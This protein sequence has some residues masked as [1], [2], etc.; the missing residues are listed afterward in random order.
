MGKSKQ[1]YRK[2]WEKELDGAES[3]GVKSTIG[4]WCTVAKGDDFSG[5]CKVCNSK[6]NVASAGK[7]AIIQHA[8]FSK[9]RDA[10]QNLEKCKQLSITSF[11]KPSTSTEDLARTAEI[12]WAAFLAENDLPMILSDK[13]SDLFKSMFPDSDI[14]KT[15]SCARTKASY[16]ITGGLGYGEHLRIIDRMKASKFS[17]LID[18]STQLQGDK[19][20]HILARMFDSSKEAVVTYFYKAI[21]VNQATAENIASA[22]NASFDADDI[23]WKNVIQIMSDSPNVMRGSK[24]GVLARIKQQYASHLLDIGGCSLHHVHNAV[25]YATSKLG[26]EIEEFA[27]D[28]FAFFKYRSGLWEEYSGLQVLMD[29]PEHHLLRFVSTR[30]LVMLPV[31]N[32]LLEQ[33]SCVLES[34]P[35]NETQFWRCQISVLET[36]CTDMSLPCTW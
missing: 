32:R 10:I 1:R 23:P 20:L 24:S 21:V 34:D 35:A 8:K 9:H 33:W 36:T 6:I 7:H 27:I 14:A 31:V 18:E 15:F 4:D 16:L 13:A 12:R 5:Y 3:D 17:I 22:I 29:I 25:S 19:Y 30:W 11:A 2:D 26:D 28:V